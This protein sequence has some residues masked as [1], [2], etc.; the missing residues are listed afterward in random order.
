[1]E[2][3]FFL[4]HSTASKKRMVS[5]GSHIKTIQWE[6]LTYRRR[7][8]SLSERMAD[9]VATKAKVIKTTKMNLVIF[10]VCL[11]TV[12]MVVCWSAAF[13]YAYG[14][15]SRP[16]IGNKPNDCRNLSKSC[17][18]CGI[19]LTESNW[20]SLHHRPR[21]ITQCSL[22]RLSARRCSPY[23]DALCIILFPIL[24]IANRQS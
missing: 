7:F 12:W 20:F 6:F 4:K 24:K 1:M 16:W 21:F 14:P 15:P 23:H 9:A 18:G 8:W 17:V 5:Y 11:H 13:L 10:R 3:S 2:M 22:H 19:Q